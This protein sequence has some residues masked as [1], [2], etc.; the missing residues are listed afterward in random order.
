MED[1]VPYPMS[2]KRSETAASMPED[3]ASNIRRPLAALIWLGVVFV[4]SLMPFVRRLLAQWS[5]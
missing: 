4:A 5:R 1:I 3:G 2:E